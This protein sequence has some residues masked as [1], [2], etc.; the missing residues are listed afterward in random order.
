MQST[1]GIKLDLS[2]TGKIM[3]ISLQEYDRELIAEFIN[4]AISICF[5]RE[6]IILHFLQKKIL[7]Q[8]LNYCL[9]TKEAEVV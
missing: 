9:T 5:R 7:H 3:L 4:F 1:A 2:T 8:D 6:F